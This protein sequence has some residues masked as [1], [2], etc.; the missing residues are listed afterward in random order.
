MRRREFIT[1]IGGAALV[2]DNKAVTQA[3]WPS[4]I[5]GALPR[6]AQRAAGHC[7]AELS[8]QDGLRVTTVPHSLILGASGTSRQ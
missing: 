6:I 8:T 5:P 2:T 1:L 3:G 7:V 4:N